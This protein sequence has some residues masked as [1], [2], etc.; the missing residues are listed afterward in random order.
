MATFTAI[1]SYPLETDETPD[2]RVAKLGDGY[3]QRSAKSIN[4]LAQ[5]WPLTFN[6]RTQEEADDIRTFLRARGGVESFDWTPPGEDD[7]IK[8][9]CRSWKRSR[10][11]AGAYTVTA[12]FEQVFEP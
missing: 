3:E 11:A 6:N 1:P 12:T 4:A 9:V 8:V 7:A 10:G 2:V 5:V